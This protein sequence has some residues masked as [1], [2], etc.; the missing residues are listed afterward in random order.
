MYNLYLIRICEI[1]YI[2]IKKVILIRILTIYI[3]IYIYTPLSTYY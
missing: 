2:K 3:Y 1:N